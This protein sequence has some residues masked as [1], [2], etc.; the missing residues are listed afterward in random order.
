MTSTATDTDTPSRSRRTA[1]PRAARPGWRG[2]AAVGAG[3]VLALVTTVHAMARTP[4]PPLLVFALV[5][6]GILV[7]LRRGPVR[8]AAGM[9]LLLAAAVAPIDA[10]SFAGLALYRDPYEFTLTVGAL[11]AFAALLAG[12]GVL[13]V[14]GRRAGGD[15][16]PTALSTVA[17]LAVVA[18]LG[19]SI[20]SRLAAPEVVAAD[21]D[22]LVTT[23]DIAFAP[24]ELRVP[25]GEVTFFVDNLDPVGHTFTVD[26][27]GLDA[28]VAG[29][30]AVR[31][32]A[33]AAPG[34]YRYVCSLEGHDQMVGTLVVD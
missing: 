25:A 24:A 5:A 29:T 1:A 4:I 21:G 33:D 19:F 34:E 9:A 26:A 12:G 27:L 6:A 3:L 20:G 14:R 30:T 31:V 16:L 28:A 13:M 2:L 7:V 8:L 10:A 15:R 32:T 17:V 18:A 11:V 23:R 22:V